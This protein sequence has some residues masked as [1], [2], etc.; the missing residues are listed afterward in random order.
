MA[1]LTTISDTIYLPN[2]Q[3]VYAGSYLAINWPRFTTA[4]GKAV[5]PGKILVPVV[6]GAFTYILTANDTSTPSV[7]YRVTYHLKDS[8]SKDLDIWQESWIVPTTDATI[9]I[10]QIAVT[11]PVPVVGA[12]TI[13]GKGELVTSNGTTLVKIAP[14]A[15][16]TVL[17]SDSTVPAGMS[18]KAKS[19]TLA[20]GD[21]IIRGDTQDIRL[22]VGAD[23]QI[24]VSDST[25]TGGV[26]WSLP[27]PITGRG[28]Y[29][30]GT[31]YA[32]GQAVSYN[33]GSYLSLLNNNTGN[34]PDTATTYWM[35]LG[36]PGGSSNLA[37]VTP[38]PATAAGAV[39]A[40]N[41]AARQDHVHPTSTIVDDSKFNNGVIT[42]RAT[43]FFAQK[44]NLFNI[45][46]VTTGTSIQ[47][48]TGAAITV[49]GWTASEYIP[50]TVGASYIWSYGAGTPA[51]T[52][53][54]GAWFNAAKVFISGITGAGPATAPAG[55][56]YMRVS[57]T[58]TGTNLTS[59]QVVQSGTLPTS[60]TAYGYDLNITST[61]FPVFV[62]EAAIAPALQT[63][64]GG[65]DAAIGLAKNTSIF[66]QAQMKYMNGPL[67]LF[68]ATDPGVTV[69]TSIQGTTGSAIGNVGWKA[70]HYIPV[71]A[72]ATYLVAVNTTPAGANLTNSAWYTAAKVYIS[73]VTATA[74][75]TTAPANAAYL[76]I[77]QTNL[78]FATLMLIAGSSL[79]YRYAPYAWTLAS[80]AGAHHR[81]TGYDSLPALV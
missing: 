78:P 9:T 69:D 19:P 66:S 17:T 14:G 2:G 56:A 71:T 4:S 47:S 37:T 7:S 15:D 58:L 54:S 8:D 52:T 10:S 16:G 73:G 23:G 43:S 36:A 29:S 49:G 20:K 33:G 61:A 70:T 75:V 53:V 12:V 13:T 1:E 6:N 57:M 77:S 45:N 5:P 11:G 39:G 42:P 18:Y 60:F 48:T 46:A 63:A 27:S 30:A 81:S 80:I 24:L 55:A 3:P 22:T 67:N 26:K 44:A 68:D 51:G 40:S 35:V 41:L 59:F 34:Q 74:G 50:V 65:A 79:P 28:I 76:R 72:S 38:L 64:Q 31:T 62:P 32:V 25:Q 21:L